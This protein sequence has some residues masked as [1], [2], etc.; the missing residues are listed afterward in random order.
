MN[1]LFFATKLI[2]VSKGQFTLHR[3]MQTTPTA[4]SLTF[5]D[6]TNAN[7]T[8]WKLP[9]I[10]GNRCQR[11]E[12]VCCCLSVSV[13]AVRT[14]LNRF[15]E[16]LKNQMYDKDTDTRRITPGWNT[17]YIVGGIQDVVKNEMCK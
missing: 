13:C 7:S 9:P 1:Q 2:I 10:N 17:E 15:L 16:H 12:C 4:T 14:G 6:L 5:Q 8:C 11:G 3:Q